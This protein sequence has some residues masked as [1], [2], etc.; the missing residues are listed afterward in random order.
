MPVAAEEAKLYPSSRELVALAYGPGAPRSMADRL[1]SDCPQLALHVVTFRNGTVISITWN[2]VTCDLGGFVAILKA[3]VAHLHSQSFPMLMGKDDAMRHLYE[4][5]PE[6]VPHLFGD[7]VLAGWRKAVW[8]AQVLWDQWWTLSAF[9]SQQVCIPKDQMDNL[10]KRCQQEAAETCA[11]TDGSVFISEGDVIMALGMRAAAKSL[12]KGT[13]RSVTTLTATDARNRFPEIY[14]EKGAY[15]Q[16]MILAATLLRPVSDILNTRLGALALKFRESLRA[17]IAKPQMRKTAALVYDAIRT[18][19]SL[20]ISGDATTSLLITANWSKAQMLRI[21][22]LGPAVMSTTQNPSLRVTEKAALP[23]AF[24]SIPN[25]QPSLR[26]SVI[27]IR[28]R[29][30]NGDMWLEG[31]LASAGWEDMVAQVNI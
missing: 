23:F 14:D 12:P 24:Y 30:H 3:W 13:R 17:Q 20:P 1:A 26:T 9:T 29:D 16:N 7:T 8:I 22:D 28:G 31:E 4:S 11:G 2:H 15:I 19:R 21:L 25:A 27:N 6:D 5:P 18:S 10:M